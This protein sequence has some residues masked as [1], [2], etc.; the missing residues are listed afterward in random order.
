[1]RRLLIALAAAA[2]VPVAVADARKPVIAYVD[3][4]AASPTFN[5]LRLYDA[6]TG[7]HVPGPDVTVPVV[8]ARRRFALSHGGRFVA[9]VDSAHKIHLI[10]RASGSEVPLPGIDVYTTERPGSLSLSNTGRIA[11]DKNGE[12]P[13]VVYDSMTSLFV[14]TGL[15]ASNTHR[16]TAISGHGQF[17]A[18]T[19]VTQC[20]ANQGGDSSVFVQDLNTRTDTGFP[21]DLSG[22]NDKDEE[23]PCIDGDGS[24]VGFDVPPTSP[25]VFLYDRAAGTKVTLPT[26]TNS[27][28]TDFYCALDDAADYLGYF[29]Q[30][31]TDFTL[32]L[33]DLKGGAVAALASVNGFNPV[34]LTAPYPPPED[35]DPPGG[36]Q[37]PPPG[38]DKTAP[39]FEG[40][41]TVSN[42]V[43]RIG[44]PQAARRRPAPR[45][46]RFRYTLSEAATVRIAIERR[47]RGRRVGRRCRPPSRRLRKRRRCTRW[48]GR[49]ALEVPAVAGPNS[50][51]FSGRIGRRALAPARYRGRLVATDAVGNR[52]VERRV[53]FR[54]VRR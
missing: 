3:E 22:A 16:Q 46:T 42:P 50:T 38:D 4:D 31:A 28:D 5:K 54:I 26:G 35:P 36:E 30:T 2:L 9:W 14:D 47:A 40:S 41:V 18:T 7:S 23:H 8:G 12:G 52:S 24:Q 6:E 27:S 45:G 17:L 39:L 37:P 53:S 43:F 44:T 51:P 48:L 1:V 34:W 33:A 25:D 19:C 21:D 13:A 49:G 11:F 15:G 10:D 29:R 32:R 20:I